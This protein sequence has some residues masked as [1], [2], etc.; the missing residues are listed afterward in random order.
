MTVK[1]RAIDLEGAFLLDL[2]EAVRG[3]VTLS[4]EQG[5]ESLAEVQK[6]IE[7]LAY[8]E[9][10]G[11]GF[12][13]ELLG[14]FCTPNDPA[15]DRILHKAA[16]AL[17]DAQLPDAL[18]G[19]ESG[20][21]KRVWEMASAIYTAVA[22]LGLAYALPPTSFE[23]DGQKIRLPSQ[24]LDGGVATCLDTSMLFAAALEKI[25]LNPII[26]M[27]E[28]H[29][30]VGVWLQPEELSNVV[31]EDAE[32][33][34]KRAELKDLILIETT[35][36]TSQP[37]PPF[38]RALE[39]AMDH[40][41]A[42]QDAAFTAAV[43]ISRARAHQIKPLGLTRS[44]DGSDARAEVSAHQTTIE[45]APALPDFD[46]QPELSVPETPDGRVERWQRKLLDLT[47]RN[48][49]L[50]H[51]S[52]K[53]S[54]PLLCPDPGDLEDRLAAGK[55]ITIQAAPKPTN[56]AQDDDLHRQRT[57]T[58]ISREYALDALSRQQVLVDM[59][60][61]DLVTRAV[62]IYR[63]A[64]TSLQEGG[65]NTLYLA[66]GFLSWKRDKD[67]DRRFNAPLILLP[68]TLERQSVRSGVK[69]LSHDDEPRFNTTLLEMLRKDFEIDIKGLDGDLPKDESGVDVPGIWN[70]VRQA[71]KEAPGFEVTEDVV[72]G[73]FSFAKYLMWKDL[74]DRTEYLR[75]NGIVRHLIDTPRQSYESGVAFVD[76]DR[77][78][79]DYAP[80]DL[81][82]PLPADASQMAAIASADRGKDFIVIG[83]PGTGKSQTISNTIAH[84]LGKGKT[85][86]F[87]SEKTAALDVVHRRLSDIGLGQFCL[88]LH[89]NKAKKSEVLAQLSRAWNTSGQKTEAAWRAEAEQLKA[90]RDQLNGVVDYMHTR[91]RNGLTPHYAI[92]VCVRDAHLAERFSLS[93]SHAEEH[94]ADDLA[95]MRAAADRLRIQAMA[96]GD[97]HGSPFQW[98]AM[99]EWSPQREADVVDRAR[100][101]VEASTALETAVMRFTE[102][103][104]LSLPDRGLER[105]EALGELAA[106]MNAS[107]RQPTG[108]ALESDGEDRIEAL[109]EA[110]T[111]LKTYA[112]AQSE[113]S[114]TY[115]PMAW[116][117]LDGEAIA[118][119]WAEAQRAWWPKRLFAKRAV[120]KKLRA[121]GAKGK[122]DPVQDA[123][124]LSTL[125][126]EGEAIDRLDRQLTDFRDWSAHDTDPAAAQALHDLG[127]RAR[128]AVGRLMDE[129][130]Q[131]IELRGRI[132]AMLQDGNDMLAPDGPLGRAAIGY[133]EAFEAFQLAAASLKSIAGRELRELVG[134]RD[135]ALPF[136]K[137]HL[138]ALIARRA[139]LNEW[140]HWWQRRQ[141]A[142]DCGLEPL[143][144]S[145]EAGVT[146][147]A[148]IP[149]TFEAAY[150]AWWTRC[151]FEEDAI[152]KSWST[153][154]HT[155]AIEQFRAIDET[156][157][158]VTADYIAATL[159]GRIPD[160]QQIGTNQA[161]GT[162]KKLAA[163]KR[164]RVPIRQMI[165][166]APE[167]IAKLAPCVMMSPLSI[168]QYLPPD[169]ALFDVVIFDEASQITVWDAVGAIA[170]GQQVI[171]AG[172]P[173][174]MP[175][176]NFFGRTDEDPD[177]EID[178]DGDMESILDELQSASIPEQTLNLHY[179]S[180]RES[181]IAFSNHH[182]YDN[183]LVTFPAP[184]YPDRGVRL[185]K[186]DGYYARGQARHNVGEAHAVVAE[187][188]RRLTADDP[189]EQNRSIGVVT[190]NAEQQSLIL[191]LLDK[192]RGS[193]PSIEWAFA[194]D[195]AEA[196]FV[197]NLETV[198]GDERDV[199][200][201]SI[202][203]GPDQAGRVAMNFGPLNRDGGERRLNVAMT[204]ARSEMV[205]FSTLD[206]ETI[207]LSRT[208]SEAVKHLKHF[209]EYAARGPRVLGTEVHGS[210]G[211]FESPFETAVARALQQR[212]WR[213]RPQIGVS[214]F[215]VDLG[216]VHPDKAGVYLAGVECDG[217]MYHSSSYARERDKIRQSVLEGLEWTLVRV[218]STD[219]WINRQG[220]L[221]ALD[222][223]LQAHLAAD[224]AERASCE[225]GIDA[226]G[227][228][229][230]EDGPETSPD[231]STPDDAVDPPPGEPEHRY[232]FAAF[233]DD[234]LTADAERFYD[235]DYGLRLI[236]MVER[237]IDTEGPIH[238]A[239]LVGRIAQH[240]GFQRAGRRIRERVFGIA[241]NRRAHT[242]EDVGCFFWPEKSDAHAPAPAP[243]RYCGRNATLR[244]ID[245]IC[246]EELLAISHALQ[247]SD[248]REIAHTLGIGRLSAA[249]RE[250]LETIVGDE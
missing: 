86:L 119:Q 181:L 96:V 101:L 80:A 148:E 82:A 116:R 100:Q 203:Y 185:V 132:R 207:D 93:G 223:K 34:R 215:R 18:N 168:A 84:L 240:H 8:N 190:F 62:E 140:C 27:P 99:A 248:P 120:T 127:L 66:L 88:E 211:D 232:R 35:L 55:K 28:G 227:P 78:D 73:H 178:Y 109:E 214:A 79:R 224:R 118:Q 176:G 241:L 70:R 195:K 189:T 44:A 5:G 234:G 162:I 65:A 202:T 117:T 206:P 112:S 239:I 54:L 77:L 225:P 41:R 193:N 56:Q 108:F 191:D 228:E 123:P 97:V 95:A 147:A 180:R 94:S 63:K 221:D 38:S 85:V 3:T 87:V 43:D 68:V 237:V 155:D 31:G 156:F 177:G 69:M 138:E 194:E 243:A 47:A 12:M 121:G 216:V 107:Y 22:N 198:Q 174:Q 75:A 175:P 136:I 143:V 10:G 29:A 45:A 197:K 229:A 59:R 15:V 209:L 14:A 249:A 250:R 103:L 25:G 192:A 226:A 81:L 46:D 152:L 21:R 238:E 199:I 179:R 242:E 32:I 98:V 161:W 11:A 205:V 1:D 186:C 165:A 50:N 166:D 236:E 150:C 2:T 212:G 92:G 115:A 130:D 104:K 134:N 196:V 89:S 51:K 20:S 213:V 204:R 58:V 201:F 184:V 113:L 91:R 235:D 19:Y 220:A 246:A 110:V 145:V 64:Q 187:I 42:D 23:R 57:G 230:V 210:I 74:V 157:Q 173:K 33:L 172:D 48:P 129:P 67:Q 83:P 141:E 36:V 105:L 245:R 26:V 102:A 111:R 16:T 170:R 90:V 9:W 144:H 160:R 106:V 233:D 149:E 137:G 159:S 17:R 217:A 122:P 158:R 167:P 125:R 49:L 13:P 72:L 7:V 114:V 146:P 154:E 164:P 39:R 30:L 135:E 37:A 231:Q 171:V 52:T 124:R 53:T 219:W 218:W 76:S 151:L 208:N 200:L 126:Y 61:Q 4:V 142:I 163:Q 60:E 188:V 40:L 131:L 24:I 6:P 244:R 183:R 71:I 247:T 139:E 182:Y 133:V 128:Q 153:A 222:T 169:Q